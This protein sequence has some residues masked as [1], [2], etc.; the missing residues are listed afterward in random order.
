MKEKFLKFTAYF[1][2]FLLC[3]LFLF[4]LAIPLYVS[5]DEVK[6]IDSY[7]VTKKQSKELVITD[8]LFDLEDFQDRGAVLRAVSNQYRGS[9]RW[10]YLP[11]Q[12]NLP[13]DVSPD[14]AV[15]YWTPDYEEDSSLILSEMN[16]FFSSDYQTVL[17]LRDIIGSSNSYALGVVVSSAGDYIE[18]SGSA[19]WGPDSFGSYLLDHLFFSPDFEKALFYLPQYSLIY[20]WSP[21]YGYADGLDYFYYSNS[22]VGYMPVLSD[23]PFTYIDDRILTFRV[24]SVVSSGS[25]TYTFGNLS[26]SKKILNVGTY[27]FFQT[28]FGEKFTDIYFSTS[29]GSGLFGWLESTFLP[30]FGVVP[31]D[32]IDV[33]IFGHYRPV[34]VIRLILWLSLTVSVCVLFVAL[35]T[36]LILKL[37]GVKHKKRKV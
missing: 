4:A 16:D 14:Y 18:Q 37:L 29:A 31:T 2:L 25:F 12:E 11:D 23:C 19:V 17:S 9:F 5:A 35:P 34:A 1:G 28:P 36:C 13:D 3:F 21:F 10:Q 15:S 6:N 27:N 22:A 30:L 26:F 8:D 33:G 7:S 32:E 24:R 20:S